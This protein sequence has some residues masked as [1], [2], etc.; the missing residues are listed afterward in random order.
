MRTALSLL[1][2]LLLLGAAAWLA[3]LGLGWQM[4]QPSA[5]T[6]PVRVQVAPGSSL[7]GTLMVLAAAGGAATMRGW[8]SCTCACTGRRRVLQAGTLRDRRRMP[9]RARFSI[10]STMAA[11]CWNSITVVEGWSF[12]QMRHALDAH[13]PLAHQLRG[14]T[15]AAADAGAGSPGRGRRGPTSSP[16]PTVSRPVPA[17]A[18]SWNALCS[19]CRRSSTAHWDSRA[20]DLP[21]ANADQALILASIVEKE[22]G[23]EDERPKVAA[24]FINRLRTGHA[25]AIRSD[26]DLRTRRALRRQHPHAAI[27]RPIRPTTP[28]P[29]RACRRR[30]SRCRGPRRCRRRCTRR[31]SD[32]LYFVAT[33]NGD[34]THHFSATLA[35]HD[36]GAARLPAQARACAGC[37]SAAAPAAP[38]TD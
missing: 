26:R 29:A 24:V 36:V 12:A 38:G 10:S 18:R 21:L 31:D 4:N 7:R 3:W 23:R 34:G 6:A 5:I 19:A 32:A 27:W 15:D 8:W 37:E 14:L 35:E 13:P 30:R 16:I 25:P 20:A 17:T 22:T 1:L 11:C 28:I 2:L 9:A 33:G